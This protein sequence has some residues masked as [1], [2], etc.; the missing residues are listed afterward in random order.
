[1]RSVDK[2]LGSPIPD[3]P[4]SQRACEEPAA[5]G[6]GKTHRLEPISELYGSTADALSSAGRRE[7]PKNGSLSND[8]PARP[9][10]SSLTASPNWSGRE[11]RRGLQP[12]K[13][14]GALTGGGGLRRRTLPPSPPVN[15]VSMLGY[16]RARKRRRSQRSQGVG[17]PSTGESTPLGLPAQGGVHQAAGG[18]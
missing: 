4:D 18:S 5:P 15:D 9:A 13:P 10:S 8:L 3:L 17:W 16:P 14:F 11:V 2:T 12:G 7:S 6:A 1:M